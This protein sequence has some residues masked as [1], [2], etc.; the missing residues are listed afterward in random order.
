[1]GKAA[2]LRAFKA[3]FDDMPG[4]NTNW[5]WNEKQDGVVLVDEVFNL[6]ELIDKLHAAAGEGDGDGCRLRIVGHD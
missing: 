4:A 3:F 1:M 5:D 2:M 6:D